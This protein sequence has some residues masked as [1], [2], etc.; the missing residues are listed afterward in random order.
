[1]PRGPRQKISSHPFHTRS[2]NKKIPHA[3]N[4]KSFGEKT[5]DGK[6]KRRRKMYEP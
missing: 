4:I 5:S 6:R 3:H 2:I 1:L